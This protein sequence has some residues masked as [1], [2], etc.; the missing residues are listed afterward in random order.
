MD[1]SIFEGLVKDVVANLYDYAALETHPLLYSVFQPP[2]GYNGS[3]L[4]YVRQ[5][6]VDAIEQLRPDRKEANPSAPEWRPYLILYKRYVEGLSLP[7]LS[8]LLAVSD[9]QIRRDHHRA[10]QALANLLWA[11]LYP[12]D[13]PATAESTHAD[14]LFEVHKEAIDPLETVR[15]VHQ[16]LRARLESQGI[17]LEYDVDPNPA[18]VLTDRVVLRQILI[19]LFNSAVHLHDSGPI[20]IR[21]FQ[22]GSEHCLQISVTLPSGWEVEGEP[23][24][25]D[26]VGY[27]LE[28]INAR[29][30]KT[31]LQPPLSGGQSGRT[32]VRSLYLPL[33]G[34]KTVL[35]VDDQPP[36]IALFRRYLSQYGFNIVGVNQANQALD[37]AVRLHPALI[38]LD[39]MMPKT[40]GWEV[41]QNLK[42]N[43]ET[44]DIP[45]LICSAWEEPE[46]SQSLGAAGFLKK[47][48]TQK[49]LLDAFTR[50]NLF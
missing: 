26:T 4:E 40:D 24:G 3:R 29:M 9:R 36:A 48:I 20:L 25:Q 7:D 33:L 15:G 47:P 37:M 19:S 1:Q 49:Q 28:R 14:A 42:S 45:V 21:S 35:V 43:E 30:E 44:R 16:I 11:G 5:V 12:A 18:S 46:L 38:T 32:Y 6:F 10:M 27:W 2:A 41:L 34:S 22:H 13:T 31:V 39:V 8:A 50:L 17:Q 23:D